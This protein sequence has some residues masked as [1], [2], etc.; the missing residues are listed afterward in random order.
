MDQIEVLARGDANLCTYLAHL[1]AT[2]Q[3]GSFDTTDGVLT[4]AGGHAYPGT[5]TNGV[6]RISNDADAATV[7][8]RAESFFRPLRRGYAVWIRDHADHDLEQL[9]QDAG[10]FQRPPLEGNPAIAYQGP[11][12]AVPNLS[13]RGPG[14]VSIRRVDDDA[15]RAAYLDGVLA[16]YGVAG[17]PP[18]LADRVIFRK[19]SLDD[20]RVAAFVAY[21]DESPQSGCMAFL[22]GDTAGMQWGATRPDARGRGLGKATFIAAANA[23]IDDGA[24]LLT[25][26]ASQMG[27][28]LWVS[29]GCEVVTHYRRYLA[30][31]PT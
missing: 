15:S 11:R 10:M 20:P 29:L 17:L 28:P 31:P 13:G 6:T 2:A 3:G 12:F 5:Y 24:T 19:A 8:A 9:A 7:L 22:D 4:F 30:K 1:A 26:Q 16:G 21:I 23:A 18:E 27:V 25:G 14:E